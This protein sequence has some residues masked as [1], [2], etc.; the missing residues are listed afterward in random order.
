MKGALVSPVAVKREQR[1]Y[2]R[3]SC[4]SGDVRRHCA[5]CEAEVDRLQRTCSQCYAPLRKECP[6]C[7]Y[8]V[9]MDAAYCVSC[10][11]PFQTP[12]PRKAVIKMWHPEGE[13]AV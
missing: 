9:E 11:R 3:P 2:P 8:W 6:H 4:V 1:H 10:R 5:C 13:G 12:P 7:H